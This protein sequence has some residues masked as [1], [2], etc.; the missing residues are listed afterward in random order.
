M[1]PIGLPPPARIANTDPMTVFGT[2]GRWFLVAGV[3]VAGAALVAHA[4]L[5]GPTAGTVALVLAIIAPTPL[6]LG[7]VFTLVQLR[8]FGSPAALARVAA[9]GLRTTATITDVARSSGQIN[10][11]PIMRLTLSINGGVRRHSVLVPI[12]YVSGIR[13]GLRLPVR[14][15]PAFPRIVVVDWA[16]VP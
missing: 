3:G 14:V 4:F 2:L 1:P 15:D 10:A 16:S 13:P 8:T 11:D 7:T 12:Q 6:I 9:S 5:S